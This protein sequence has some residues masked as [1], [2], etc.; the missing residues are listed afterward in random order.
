MSKFELLLTGKVSRFTV[1]RVIVAALK[2]ATF[3]LNRTRQ[4]R[5]ENFKNIQ[6]S[7]SFALSLFLF[8]FPVQRILI[9]NLLS[10]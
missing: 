2:Y 10:K 1:K 6:I 5:N 9:E 8:A 3:A 4:S 7:I